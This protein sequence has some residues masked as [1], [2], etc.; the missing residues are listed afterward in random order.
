[1]YQSADSLAR[2]FAQINIYW[3][4]GQWKNLLYQY[5]RMKIEE[6]VAIASNDF[7]KEVEVYDRVEDLTAIMGNYMARG[8]IASN[9]N[10]Q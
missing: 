9:L 8:I 4:E 7:Q 2:F 5:V 1:L 3:D 6:I 10:L